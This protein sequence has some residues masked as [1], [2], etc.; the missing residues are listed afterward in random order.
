MEDMTKRFLELCIKQRNG[1]LAKDGLY[2]Y[3]ALSQQ[4]QIQSF[5]N[6]VRYF[7]EISNKKAEEAREAG[8]LIILKSFEKR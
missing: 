7:L 2:Q 3:R 6:V 1:K 8:R 5:E 4:N